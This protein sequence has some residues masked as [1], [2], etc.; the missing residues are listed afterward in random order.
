MKNKNIWISAGVVI[1]IIVLVNL[2]AQNLFLRS[3]LTEN[4]RYS[5]SDVTRDILAEIDD[6][7][8]VKIFYSEKFPRQLIAVKQYVMDMLEEYRAYAGNKLEY[9][10]IELS[11]DNPKAEQEAMRYGVQP[12]QA[13]ITE[14]DQIKVQKI[15][16]GLVFLYG[17]QKEVIPFAQNIEQLEY[18]MTGA[19]KKLIADTPAKIGWI[20]GNG[21]PEIYGADQTVERALAEIRKNYELKSI[22][23]ESTDKIPDDITVA[24]LIDPEEKFS[25]AEKYKL[26]QYLMRGGKLAVFASTKKID[27][28]NQFMPVQNNPQNL[29]DLF[30]KYGFSIDEKLIIDKQCFQVQ[31]MQ[32][33]G[34]IQIPVSVPFPFAPRLNNFNR[35]NPIVSRMKELGFFFVNRINSSIDTTKSDVEFVPLVST[36]EKSGYAM[37]DPRTRQININ[38]SNKIPDYQYREKHM[39]VAAVVSGTFSS[40]FG[41]SR[42]D[43]ISYPDAHLSGS[44]AA[45]KIIVVGSG[46][47]LNPQ[48][49]IPSSFTFL[50]NTIDWLYDEHGL[51]S[52]RSKDI[53]PAQLE[54]VSQSTKMIIKWINILLAP[55]L[56]I[57]FGFLRWLTRKKVKQLAGGKV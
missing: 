33:L 14:S 27:L 29:N 50:L 40:A 49:M 22:D 23:L 6:P 20:T 48:F 30:N 24:L 12:V 34:P 44:G 51:I 1:A 25:E 17:D 45:T 8:T 13:N 5:I 38:P 53:N 11:A 3:D 26:D 4:G 56:I 18:D 31:A 57:L 41:A 46:T 47:V 10:F 35:D 15:F 42:P 2:V 39:P 37:P 16:L 19:I 54:E 52:I 9:E 7:V 28:K 36:S 55:L 43:S 21:E 32:N